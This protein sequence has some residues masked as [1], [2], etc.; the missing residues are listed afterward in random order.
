MLRVSAERA[1]VWNTHGPIVDDP[2]EIL[3]TT[4]RQNRHVDELCLAVGRDPHSLRRSFTSFGPFDVWKSDVSLESVVERFH[5]IGMTEFVIDLPPRDR[6][7]EFEHL[8]REVL[9]ALR[10]L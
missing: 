9:P 10:N 3:E 2:V 8:A 1:D 6:L 7:D 4:A 5:P